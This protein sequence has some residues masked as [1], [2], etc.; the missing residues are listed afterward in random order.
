[1]TQLPP[2]PLPTPGPGPGAATP[3]PYD[4]GP[5]PADVKMGGQAGM[6]AAA[7]TEPKPAEGLGAMLGQARKFITAVIGVIAIA[8]TQGLIEGTAAKWAG[9]IVGI[10]TAAGV[11][12]VPND[13]PPGR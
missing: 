2:D 12:I 11:Y 4:Q 6:T 10:A 7:A 13:K 3:P 9:T 8:L 1:M 5:V